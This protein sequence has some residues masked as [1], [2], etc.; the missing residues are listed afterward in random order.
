MA[1]SGTLET[2]R[3]LLSR[4]QLRRSEVAEFAGVSVKT[5]DKAIEQKAL[6]VKKGPSG[7]ALLDPVSVVCVSLFKQAGQ[8]L[9]VT[10]RRRVCSLAYRTTTDDLANLEL[11]LSPGLVVRYG[12]ASDELRR[13]LAYTRDRDRFIEINPKIRRGD[14][15]IKDTR[16]SV[17]GL[18]S[19]VA[20]GDTIEVLCDDYPYVPREAIETALLYARTNPRRG[21]RPAPAWRKAA[22]A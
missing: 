11:E 18:A 4:P 7:T 14:P 16:I 2:K 12:A 8:R 15:V 22:F 20:D 21:R 5:V 9:P 1:R 19:R 10:D 17:Y 6:R 3:K 13:A